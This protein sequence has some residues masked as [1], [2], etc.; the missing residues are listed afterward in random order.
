MRYHAHQNDYVFSKKVVKDPTE[1]I[2]KHLKLLTTPADPIFNFLVPETMLQLMHIIREY[3]AFQQDP[4]DT[5]DQG[6]GS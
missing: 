5:M 4:A 3:G 6:E 1:D 2:V